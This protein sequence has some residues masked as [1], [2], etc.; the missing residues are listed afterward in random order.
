[1]SLWATTKSPLLLSGDLANWS[2]QVTKIATNEDILEI[3]QDI[4][5]VQPKCIVNCKWWDRLLR[6]P[7][8]YTS[9][10]ADGDIIATATNWQSVA[11]EEVYFHKNQLDF[12]WGKN[13][14]LHIKDLWA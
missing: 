1:M 10:L 11:S 4:T 12:K 3:N 7:T 2:D 13:D 9:K 8:V 14:L 5:Q 6:E